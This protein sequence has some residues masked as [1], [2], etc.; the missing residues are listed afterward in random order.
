MLICIA[1]NFFTLTCF[2]IKRNQ[3]IG[4]GNHL[5]NTNY[6]TIGNIKFIYTIK[7]YLTKPWQI[8][9]KNDRKRKNNAKLLVKQ[10]LMQH[11]FFSKFS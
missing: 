9:I 10:F 2:F 8:S 3:I 11:Q 7:Y 4:M 5:T 6:S 1:H